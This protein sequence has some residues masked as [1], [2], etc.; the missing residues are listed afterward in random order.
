V[1]REAP[2]ATG[3]SI[4]LKALVRFALAAFGAYLAWIAGIDSGMGEFEVWLA[5]GAGFIITLCLLEPA[6]SFVRWLSEVARWCLIVGTG[7][8][9]LW[10]ALH[11]QSG[12]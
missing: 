7:F 2:I 6:R 8:G 4:I 3:G 12:A 5:T 9:V 1:Q 10:F 11:A